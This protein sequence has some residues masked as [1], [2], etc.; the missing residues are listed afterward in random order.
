V[1]EPVKGSDIPLHLIYVETVDGLYAP[2][3][4]RKPAGDGPFPIILFAH[5]NGGLGV[6]W[7]R[8]WTQNG[9]NPG[10]VTGDFKTH[11]DDSALIRW[12]LTPPIESVTVFSTLGNLAG[13]QHESRT[14]P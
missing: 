5:M 1:S 10:G 2:I 6:P 14:G 12:E 8:E 9:Q 4:L 13:G 11:L 3:G 7:I